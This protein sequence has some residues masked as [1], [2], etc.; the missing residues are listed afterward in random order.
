MTL[1]FVFIECVRDLA[2]SAEKAAKQVQGVLE[3][4]SIKNDGTFDLV[5]KVQTNDD[6]QFKSTISALKSI[7]GVAAVVTAI[8]YGN[9][10]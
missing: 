6:M 4:Y 10:Q 3:A 2:L 1:A 5:V 8:V 9:F 7:V